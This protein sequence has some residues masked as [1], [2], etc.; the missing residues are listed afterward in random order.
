MADS[1]QEGTSIRGSF[2]LLDVRHLPALVQECLLRAIGS[3]RKPTLPGRG[4]S[5]HCPK[6]QQRSRALG[7]LDTGRRKSR[8]HA[9]DGPVL[10]Q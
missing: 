10:H 2:H 9:T 8:H 1:G 3:E 6:G 5:N 7:E 4:R